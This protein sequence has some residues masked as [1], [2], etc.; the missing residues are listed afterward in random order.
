MAAVPHHHHHSVQRLLQRTARATR[1]KSTRPTETNTS[2][3][4]S[5]RFKCRVAIR[6]FMSLGYGRAACVGIG[7]RWEHAY[8]PHRPVS[9]AGE[10]RGVSGRGGHSEGPG[11]GDV[12][13]TGAGQDEVHHDPAERSGR[14][15]TD[16]REPPEGT[17]ADSGGDGA[18]TADLISGR[19][20]TS[21]GH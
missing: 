16:A 11:R 10:G 12:R 18:S 13:G 20:L 9:D 1:Y 6:L 15:A 19:P 17:T 14:S 5:I 21:G 3:V 7:T 2:I 8:R 4:P